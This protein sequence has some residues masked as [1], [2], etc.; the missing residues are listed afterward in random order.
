LKDLVV[1]IFRYLIVGPMY[2]WPKA[3]W[4]G[5]WPDIRASKYKYL[6]CIPAAYLILH[7]LLNGMAKNLDLLFFLRPLLS[8]ILFLAY[9]NWILW[10]PI[11][12]VLSTLL[13]GPV[14]IIL[15]FIVREKPI[16]TTHGSAYW[17]SD[18]DARIRGNLH[19]NGLFLGSFIKGKNR[20]MYSVNGHVLTC[21][22]TGSGKGIGCV[23]PNLLQYPGSIFCLDLKG[24]NFAVT[25]RRRRELCQ[26]VFVLDPFGSSGVKSNS[27]NL[28]DG[29][30]LDVPDCVSDAASLAETLVIRSQRTDHYWDDAAASLLQGLIL[31]VSS[32]EKKD[33]H[34]GTLRKIITWPEQK[35][36]DLLKGL[37]ENEELAYGIAARAANTFLAKANRER[38]GV[39]S[40]AQQHTVFLDD[41]RLTETLKT[42][43]LDLAKLKTEPQTVYLIMPTDKLKSNNRYVRAVLRQALK[44]VTK[45]PGIPASNL[46]FLLDEFAQLD[47]F[48]PVEEGI[49]VLRGYGASL[50]LLVQ[51]LSQLSAVY[52]KW[53]T[54]LAN[55]V[56]QAFG[57]QDQTTVEYISRALGQTTI[58]YQTSSNSMTNMPGNRSSSGSSTSTQLHS[59]P[60]M[61]PDEVRRLTPNNIFV[62]QQGAPPY[63]LQ[64]MNYLRDPE[65][66]GQ[67]DENPMYKRI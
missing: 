57:A 56:L 7:L 25:A 40:T 6:V 22:P 23:I 15:D 1:L 9:M 3:V 43:D 12:F 4:S 37:G 46:L 17:G 58:S 50:W 53:Q 36:H 2:T 35:L 59:R 10:L 42:S 32:L 67:F 21:A 51:D 11:T 55:T 48:A 30:E 16:L 64:S 5:F 26:K 29:I 33:R 41:I 60:L 47:N 14:M 52:P 45:V 54:F 66:Q 13:F 63:L 61:M 34:I 31:Y 19:S 39:L 28:L 38:S 8:R 44:A 27:I 62:L 24:E 65:Y 49:S 18:N 20:L